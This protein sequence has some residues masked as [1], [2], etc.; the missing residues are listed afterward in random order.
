MVELTEFWKAVYLVAKMVVWMV[1]NVAAKWVI[2]RVS[3][4]VVG[5]VE[6]MVAW[7]E[8]D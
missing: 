1:L 5:K 8:N 4:K 7:L 6:Q 3:Q 2:E